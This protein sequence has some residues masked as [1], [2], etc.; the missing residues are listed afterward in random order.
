MQEARVSPL[1]HRTLIENS[2][3]SDDERH[4]R[5]LSYLSTYSIWVGVWVTKLLDHLSLSALTPK[6]AGLISERETPVSSSRE[7]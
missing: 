4:V 3:S 5:R 1:F 6:I 7:S 2:A